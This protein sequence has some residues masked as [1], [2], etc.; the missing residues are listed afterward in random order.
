MVG[1]NPVPGSDGTTLISSHPGAQLSTPAGRSGA[2]SLLLLCGKEPGS[3]HLQGRLAVRVLRFLALAP[4]G[5]AAGEVGE[6]DSGLQLVPGLAT[7]PGSAAGRP[8]QILGREP[9]LCLGGD[10]QDGHRDG[11]CLHTATLFSR[12]YSLPAVSARL[13]RECF[14]CVFPGDFEDQESRSIG[15]QSMAKDPSGPPS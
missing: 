5:D 4:N 10:R 7:R 15:Q 2:G 3:E 6:L 12:G 11:A 1:D 9:H 8:F 13:V 14:G